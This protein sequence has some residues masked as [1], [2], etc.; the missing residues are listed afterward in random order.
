MFKLP[1]LL[2]ETN[3]FTPWL[4][5][6]SFEYHFG[7]HHKAYVDKLNYA[8]EGTANQKLKLEEI[9]TKSSGGLFNNASQAWNHTFFWYGITPQE[10]DI[11][12]H[13]NILQAVNK[14]F[15]SLNEFKI[16]FSKIA[17]AHFGSGWAWLVKDKN[18]N[19]EVLST[20]NAETPMTTSKTPL[21]TCDL[22]E[23]AYYIDYRNARPKF[24]DGFL[25]HI[26][27]DF[28]ETNFNGKEIPDMTTLMR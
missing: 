7:K 24:I 14:S 12:N 4:S 1:E 16:Q 17:A 10:V 2:Y 3:S 6:E 20:S 15:G 13:T 5:P 28:V 25:K 21:L 22:W 19:L 27:W 11:A 18:G 9:V 23:H 26:N 8:I